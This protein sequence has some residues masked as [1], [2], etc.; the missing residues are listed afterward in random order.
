VEQ[1]FILEKNIVIEEQFPEYFGKKSK[2]DSQK[3]TLAEWADVK[4]FKH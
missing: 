1:A 2:E 3:K 4:F